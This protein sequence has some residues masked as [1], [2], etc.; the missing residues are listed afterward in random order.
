MSAEVGD[1][2]EGS[3]QSKNRNNSENNCS[4]VSRNS[5]FV[6]Q[7]KKSNFVQDYSRIV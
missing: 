5:H 2:G 7:S 1:G 6:V 3:V 4:S